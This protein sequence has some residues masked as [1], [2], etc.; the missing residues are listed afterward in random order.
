M[1]D[2]SMVPDSP[3]LANGTSCASPPS[4]SR[5]ATKSNSHTSSVSS[6]DLDSDGIIRE[7]YQSRGL[8][9]EVAG[10][11]L[12]SWREST[13]VQYGSHIKKW[14]SFCFGR[15]IDLFQPSSA[16]LLD[17]LLSEFRR[18]AGRT[19]S[20]INTL[21]SAISAVASIN[22]Q[23]AGQH[24]LA[25]RFMKAV[26][27]VRPSLPRYG[28]T[29]DPHLILDHII[30]LGPDK[31]LSLIQLSRKLTILML[32]LSGQRGQTLHMLDIRN[33]TVS[34][35]R[36]SFRI[37]DPL[38]TSR[39]GTHLSELVFVAYPPDRRLCVVTSTMSYL[40]RTN[41]MRGSLTGFFLTTRPPVKL[42]S[43]DT[44][45]RWTKDVMRAAGIN[46]GIFSPHS[47]RSASASKAA[48]RL[49]LSTIISTIGW[50]RESTFTKY[51]RKPIIDA[52]LTW[53]W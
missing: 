27:Q 31:D 14:L 1:A 16:D 18:G 29:W 3:P 20:S 53:S 45:R 22:G 30:G 41:N 49:P 39:P 52:G 9:P 21:R 36:V 48:L 7:S 46:L 11:L 13:R 40:E 6:V 4:S 2:S 15:K 24:P 5:A 37:G 43:R 33:M 19:Y 26:F 34:D 10:F 35:S 23:P 38:K 25:T 47:T 51:Y 12:H 8:S 50:T 32:L 42:A 17:F 28:T 44:L